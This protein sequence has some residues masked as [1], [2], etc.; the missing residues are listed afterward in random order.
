MPN[1]TVLD[2]RHI[3]K[4]FPGVVALVEVHFE[5]EEGEVHVLLG[6][7]GAGKSTLSLSLSQ[8]SRWL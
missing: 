7:N 3:R 1:K 8:Y 4:V 6:E 5:L 2:M